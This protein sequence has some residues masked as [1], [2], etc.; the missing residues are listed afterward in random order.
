MMRA[1]VWLV[2]ALLLAGCGDREPLKPEAGKALPVAP[3]G[4]RTPPDSTALLKPNTQQRPS[5]SD[6]I[7]ASLPRRSDEFSLP[8]PN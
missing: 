1:L 4:A 8:P 2:P 5:R 7:N 6:D 3:Y